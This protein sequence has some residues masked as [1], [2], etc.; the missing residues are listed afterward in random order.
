MNISTTSVRPN[1]DSDEEA[2]NVPTSP[3][4]IAVANG[5]FQKMRAVGFNAYVIMCFAVMG[6]CMAMMVVET[7]HAPISG[8]DNSSFYS[9]TIGFILGKFT[10]LVMDKL[11]SRHIAK[12]KHK[13]QQQQQQQN[14]SATGPTA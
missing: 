4:S 10:I 12:Q 7:Y 11:I 1:G 6:F 3:R 9:S 8:R 5:T 13:Q 2:D 14:A